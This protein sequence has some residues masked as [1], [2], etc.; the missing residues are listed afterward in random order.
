MLLFFASYINTKE[1]CKADFLSRITAINIE[2][3]LNKKVF[4][5][6]TKTF[7]GPNIDLSTTT[8]KR[9]RHIDHGSFNIR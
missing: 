5:L 1:N 4:T 8:V 6:I 2:F 3:Q 7:G 9:Q